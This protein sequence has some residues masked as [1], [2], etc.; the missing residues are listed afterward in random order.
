MEVGSSQRADEIVLYSKPPQISCTILVERGLL[1]K[2]DQKLPNF[3]TDTKN[4]VA[5]VTDSNVARILGSRIKTTLS[6]VFPRVSLIEVPPG[7]KSKTLRTASLIC[8]RLAKIGA[9]RKTS[10]VALGGGVVGD[11]TGFVASIYK[12]GIVS[13]QVPTTLLAQVDSSIGGKTGVDT[14][15]GKNQIGTFYQ[16]AGVF[17][18]PLALS[19]LP[20]SEVINGAAEI[21]KSS[22]VASREMFDRLSHVRDILSIAELEPLIPATCRIK[23]GI[24]SRDE[25]EE[26]LRSILNFG[27]TVG[28]AIE[29]ASNYSLSHGRSIILGMLAEAWIARQLELFESDDYERCVELLGRFLTDVSTKKKKS[30]LQILGSKAKLAKLLLQ[31]RKARPAP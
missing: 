2:L 21:V 8:D 28:H 6:T 12:R 19:T 14:E 7:E 13:F 17:I 27:H 11:L 1:A 18:D 26:N 23:A 31:T 16:P 10:L 20:S 9:D 3:L 4:G 29:S 24:V 30:T 5:I 15:W 22:I 25:K